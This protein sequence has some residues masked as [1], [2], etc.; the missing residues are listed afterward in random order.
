MLKVFQFYP[1]FVFYPR[2]YYTHEFVVFASLLLNFVSFWV[3][4]IFFL[5]SADEREYAICIHSFV[6]L[7]NNLF[8]L[9]VLPRAYKHCTEY[10]HTLSNAIN[11]SFDFLFPFGFLGGSTI[12]HTLYRTRYEHINSLLFYRCIVSVA[13]YLH[14]LKLISNLVSLCEFFRLFLK[15]GVQQDTQCSDAFFTKYSDGVWE[16]FFLVVRQN[17]GSVNV[18]FK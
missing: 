8:L 17:V 16:L 13:V 1:K 5:F 3:S 9:R 2:F 10:T 14:P 15:L 4:G 11:I 6:R 7:F 18:A 12:P